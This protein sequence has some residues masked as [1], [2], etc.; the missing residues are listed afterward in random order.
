MRERTRPSHSPPALVLLLCSNHHRWAALK[1]PRAERYTG[2]HSVWVRTIPTPCFA[3]SGW[4][5]PSPR[6][7]GTPDWTTNAMPAQRRCVPASPS[8]DLIHVLPLVVAVWKFTARCTRLKHANDAVAE[9]CRRHEVRVV[10]SLWENQTLCPSI[11]LQSLQVGLSLK[12]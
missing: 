4:E 5:H 10:K 6:S 3:H 12:L 2:W 9:R 7:S 11:S 1:S 8:P